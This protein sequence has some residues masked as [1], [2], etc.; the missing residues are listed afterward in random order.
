MRGFSRLGTKR[1]W[2]S[3]VRNWESPVRASRRS[4]KFVSTSA[5]K[6]PCTEILEGGS[7]TRISWQ[8]DSVSVVS[9]CLLAT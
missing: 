8:S 4:L 3:P 5:G 2:E 7:I 9:A 6:S 1:N